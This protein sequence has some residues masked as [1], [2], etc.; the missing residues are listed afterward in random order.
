MKAGICEEKAWG[1]LPEHRGKYKKMMWENMMAA[2]NRNL[3]HDLKTIDSEAEN[4]TN[5]TEYFTMK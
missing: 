3:R 5:G 2:G 4:R 1:I